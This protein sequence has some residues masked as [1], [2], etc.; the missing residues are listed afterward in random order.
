M[1]LS[2]LI[3]CGLIRDQSDSIFTSA[4]STQ[5]SCI[6]CLRFIYDLKSIECLLTFYMWIK[7]YRNWSIVFLISI[8]KRLVCVP[9]FI[10]LE[11]SLVVI[12]FAIYVIDVL[13]S[14]VCK[15]TAIDFKR[16]VPLFVQAWNSYVMLN[17]L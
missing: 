14:M 1:R 10:Q 3:E 5:I 11:L 12:G 9:E 17:L 7:L 4:P 2:N 15:D 6:R 16:N 13:A 8:D